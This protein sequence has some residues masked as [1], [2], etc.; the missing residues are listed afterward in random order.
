MS[1]HMPAPVA[2]TKTMFFCDQ[3]LPGREKGVREG[4]EG[5]REGG[6]GGRE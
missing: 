6:K 1:G 3:V 4:R 5:R 2:Q